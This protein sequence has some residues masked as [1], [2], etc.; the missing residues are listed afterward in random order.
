MKDHRLTILAAIL[1]PLPGG[2][3]AQVSTSKSA[4]ASYSRALS[5][6]PKKPASNSDRPSVSGP[7]PRGGPSISLIGS[8]VTAS[9]AQSFALNGNLAYVCDNN[10]VSI[11]DVTNPQSPQIVGTAASGL[12]QGSSLTYCG[13]LRGNLSVFSDQ[14]NTAAGNSPG[15]SAFDLSN[16]LQPTLIAAT[17]LNKRF[18]GGAAYIGNMAFVPTA[19]ATYVT[20]FW[21]NQLGDLLAVDLTNLSMPVL[22]GTLENPEIDAVYG[23][24]AP[25]YGVTEASSSLLYIGGTTSRGS[26]NNGVGY[27][28]AVDVSDPAA[29]KVVT[30]IAVPGTIQF[31]APLIQGN[32]AV[33]TGNSGGYVGSFSANPASQGNI[34]VGVFDVTDGRS[35][36]LVSDITTNYTVGLGGGAAQIGPSIFA[37]GGAQD[38]SGDTVLVVVDATNPSAPVITSYPTPQPF[39]SMQAVGNI[40]YATLGSGGF[41]AYSIPGNGSG[42]TFVCPVSVDAMIV[43]DR[44]A[45]IPAPAMLEA[46]AALDSFISSLQL[47]P[48]QVGVVSFTNVATVNQQLSV[49]GSPAMT[50]LNNVLPGG[51]SYIGAGIE[52]AQAQLSGPLH[53]P[54][55]TPV[56][57]VLSDGADAGA[58]NSNATLAA[59][60]AA[61][62]AGTVI[63]SLQYG[64]TPSTLMQSIA[65]SSAT[66]YLV[67]Q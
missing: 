52:A 55:A 30:Q 61:K 63:I 20:G 43:V 23:G 3:Y 8:V 51:A 17:P 66:Y 25:V 6:A 42:Q 57:I 64:S 65:T 38:S 9:P 67:S 10:E 34:V 11:I 12:F 48:D 29:M 13:L 37:F 62:A 7:L 32:I 46:K 4:A 35:P 58:P 39:S 22:E 59:A 27:V 2:S 26:N 31:G 53:N 21:D 1:L 28:Q 49:Q 50:A 19:A 56:M 47:S 40:L 15:Y 24:P 44:G 36:V 14:S 18:F 60:A 5:P 33:G 41:G 54:S 45:N 16:P